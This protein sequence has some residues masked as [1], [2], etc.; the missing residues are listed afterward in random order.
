MPLWCHFAYVAGAEQP[1]GPITPGAADV[2]HAR[3][4]SELLGWQGQQIEE[5]VFFQACGT[6]PRT[7]S[8]TQ[9][10]GLAHADRQPVQRG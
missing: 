3:T 10:I 2:S 5:K 1:I 6:F 8:T 7:S 4:L 9:H